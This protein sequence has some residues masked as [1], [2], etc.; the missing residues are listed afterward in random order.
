MHFVYICLY[1]QHVVMDHGVEPFKEN[2]WIYIGGVACN[3][4]TVRLTPD[5]TI[6]HP[7]SI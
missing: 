1:V 7:Y 2:P 5:Y 4:W 6:A 3:K